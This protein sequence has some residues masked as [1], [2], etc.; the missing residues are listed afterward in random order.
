V[1][2]LPYQDQWNDGVELRV[3]PGALLRAKID[4]GGGKVSGV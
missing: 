1:N 4:G 3:W 2:Q